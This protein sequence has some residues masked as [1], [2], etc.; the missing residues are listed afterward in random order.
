MSNEPITRIE[1]YLSEIES[2]G[3]DVPIPITRI[4]HYLYEIAQNGGGGASSADKVSYDNTES[5][6]NATNVQDAIDEV[7][8]GGGSGITYDVTISGTATG[9]V[10][11][12]EDWKGATYTAKSSVTDMLAKIRATGKIDFDGG[13]T[14]S[15][16]STIGVPVVQYHLPIIQYCEIMSA[17]YFAILCQSQGLTVDGETE[18]IV[19][20]ASGLDA[21]LDYEH[22]FMLVIGVL[23][24]GSI[25]CIPV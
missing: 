15:A 6:L 9:D 12:L 25:A 14:K 3:N 16:T 4:E 5:G 22:N 10:T 19:I 20:H 8:Q 2:G 7:A 1:K 23:E 18:G 13:L 24:G 11:N 17:E 21:S